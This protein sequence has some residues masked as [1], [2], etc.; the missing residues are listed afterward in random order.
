MKIEAALNVLQS[1]EAEEMAS[2]IV[3]Q[4]SRKTHTVR[5]VKRTRYQL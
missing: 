2:K 3:G 4:I 5:K 1:Q